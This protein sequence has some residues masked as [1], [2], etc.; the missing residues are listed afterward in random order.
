MS[1]RH[2]ESSQFSLRPQ[3]HQDGCPLWTGTTTRWRPFV[4][5]N[6]NKMAALCEL[7][8]LVHLLQNKE[9]R[10]RILYIPSYRYVSI[11]SDFCEN[12]FN[13]DSFRFH[14]VYSCWHTNSTWNIIRGY[15]YVL[16]PVQNLLLHV[17]DPSGALIITTRRSPSCFAFYTG[18]VNVC[19]I[20]FEVYHRT[21]HYCKNK[22]RL[23][24]SC[25]INLCICNVQK[26]KQRDTD[27]MALS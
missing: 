6:D 7:Q 16:F 27:G 19:V 12:L 10:S 1:T 20:S 2:G 17:P 5:C 11:L 14:S 18:Y 25:S 21:F 9:F 3:R 22:W 24:C 26:F 8:I 15:F 4:N 13:A 23:Y